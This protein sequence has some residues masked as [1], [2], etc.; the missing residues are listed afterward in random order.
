MGGCSKLAAYRSF[1]I[2]LQTLV[3]ISSDGFSMLGPIEE[4]DVKLTEDDKLFCFGEI[5]LMI[6]SPL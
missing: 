3:I 4:H 2:H 6:I 5:V 1:I